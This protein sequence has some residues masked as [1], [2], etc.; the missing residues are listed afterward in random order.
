M[1]SR[2]VAVGVLASTCAAFSPSMSGGLL[3]S[4]TASSPVGR[5]PR[6][7]PANPI[8]RAAQTKAA[9]ASSAPLRGAGARGGVRGVLSLE[10]TGFWGFIFRRLIA[11]V[12]GSQVSRSFTC[13]P[14]RAADRRVYAAPREQ[15][16]EPGRA[17]VRR[18]ADG[19]DAAQ[20]CAAGHGQHL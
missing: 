5:T 3:R 10:A 11:T 4:R 14:L 15:S 1:W 9:D 8:A 2:A 12:R 16:P 20:S 19:T 6:Y 13:V 7:P 17:R 18:A